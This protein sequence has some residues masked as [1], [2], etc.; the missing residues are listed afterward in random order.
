MNFAR[1]AFPIALVGACRPATQA[2]QLPAPSTP[3][4]RGA[5]APPCAAA[6]PETVFE[7]FMSENGDSLDGWRLVVA[8]SGT[9]VRVLL[10][11]NGAVG[12]PVELEGTVEYGR[13]T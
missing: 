4:P 13:P 11:S 3:A 5:P 7:T 6:K 10:K 1:L 8:Q 2:Q 12:A 9:R